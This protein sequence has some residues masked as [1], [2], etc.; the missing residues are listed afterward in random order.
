MRALVGRAKKMASS[1]I[2]ERNIKIRGRTMF[3]FDR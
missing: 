2:L 3:A 1:A